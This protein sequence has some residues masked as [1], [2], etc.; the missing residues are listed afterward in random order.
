MNVKTFSSNA[1]YRAYMT[2]NANAIMKDNQAFAEQNIRAVGTGTG[3]GIKSGDHETHPPYAFRSVL[4]QATPRGYESNG[5]K[6]R[7]LD[8]YRRESRI[9]SVDVPVGAYELHHSL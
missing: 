2:N 4:D 9:I 5:T 3:T 1:A 7:F 8:E 6:E